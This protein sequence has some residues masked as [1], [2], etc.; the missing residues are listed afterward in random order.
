MPFLALIFWLLMI[1]EAMTSSSMAERG[2]HEAAEA[3]ARNL[4]LYHQ[5]AVGWVQNNGAAGFTGQVADGAV[6]ARLPDVYRKSGPWL[7]TGTAGAV[8]TCATT[9]IPYSPGGYVISAMIDASMRDP[10]AGRIAGGQYMS[11]VSGLVRAAPAGCLDG[12]PAYYTG[13]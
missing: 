2:I 12:S 8:I 5:G 6:T 11:N 10:G 7:T 4:M 13:L 3:M 9:Q 1:S